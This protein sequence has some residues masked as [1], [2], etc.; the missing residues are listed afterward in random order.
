VSSEICGQDVDAIPLPARLRRL[1]LN[2]VPTRYLRS[3]QATRGSF[4]F[5]TAKTLLPLE[6]GS[7][8]VGEAG[9]ERN[10]AAG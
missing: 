7:A 5:L 2:V 10:D 4:I 3:A 9:T 6:P 8:T 1:A